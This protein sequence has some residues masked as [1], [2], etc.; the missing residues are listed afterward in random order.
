MAEL[1]RDVLDI[2]ARQDGVITRAQLLGA[3]ISKE[4][5][6]WNSGRRWRVLLP[7]VHLIG[8]EEPTERQR[9]IAAL[10]YAGPGSAITGAAAARHHG[11]TSVNTGDHVEVVTPPTRRRRTT[12]FVTIRPSLIVDADV[13]TRG[14]LSYV[15]V[16]RACVDTARDLRSA[17]AREALFIEARQKNMISLHDLAE[18]VYRLRP[19][20]AVLLHEALESAASGAWSL[21]ENRL[22]DLVGTSRVLPQA[23]ANPKVEDAQGLPLLTP[24][25]WFDDVAMAVLVHSRRHH[26]EGDQWDTTVARDAGLVSAGVVVTGVTP[27][28]IDRDGAGVLARLEAT[29]VTASRRPRPPVTSYEREGWQVLSD[30]TSCVPAPRDLPLRPTVP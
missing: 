16:G 15:G 18:W 25:L 5:V 8:R 7:R 10:L 1:S 22:L 2:L 24:D 29:Y 4:A 27:N 19:R 3:S 11:L 6:R 26:S 13:M 17:P 23:W 20:D 30:P 9:H 21:P 12:G 14:P 28:Q